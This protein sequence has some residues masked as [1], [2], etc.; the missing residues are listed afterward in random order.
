MG[1]FVVFQGS[2]GIGRVASCDGN[3]VEI[4]FFESAAEPRAQVV[5]K[6]ARD[7]RHTRLGE[8]SRVFFR[9]GA[10][11]WRAGR[12]VGGGPD[13]YFVRVPNLST[14]IEL[15]EDRLRIRWEK[16]PKDPL[17]VLLAGAHESP[18][19]R[20]ARLPVRSWLLSERAVTGSA[21]GIMSAG[22]K[23]H[24][25]QVD[26]ALRIIRDP[27]QRYLLA[28]EVGMGKTVQAGFVIRQLLIDDP[29]RKIGIIAPESLIPQWESELEQ[30]FHLSD[31]G[32]P[33]LLRASV[34]QQGW[35]DL[36]DVDLL[37]IDEAHLLAR[38]KDPR[39]SAYAELADLA[40]SVPRLLLLSATP[41][42]QD[43]TTHMALLHMLDPALFRWEEIQPFRTLLSTRR[44]LAM[45][46]FGL[47]VE[48][49][50]DNPELLEYQF[51]TVQG[52]LPDD[53]TLRRLISDAMASFRIG[54]DGAG[55]DEESLNRQ[56]AAV[57]THISE[58]YRLHHR[59]IRNRRHTVVK[60]QRDD[61]GIA[62]PFEFTGRSRPSVVRLDSG[63]TEAAVAAVD[64]WLSA[65]T[66]SVFDDELDAECYGAVAGILVSK[67]GG[68]VQDLQSV[69]E[70]RVSGRPTETGLSVDE[71]TILE[72]APLLP[73]E[74]QILASLAE[75]SKG[76]ALES[77][78][79]AI[80]KRCP[81]QARSLVFCGQ[82]ALAEHLHEALLQS[83]FAPA[84]VHAHLAGQGAEVREQA[85][86]DWHRDGGVLVVDETG[87]VGH[88][89]QRAERVIHAR[90]PWNPNL[91]EQRIGRVDRYG[92]SKTARH[93]VVSDLTREGIHGAW[94]RLLANGYNIFDESISAVQESIDASNQGAWARLIH[95]GVEGFES[96]AAKI[97][98]A[99]TESRRRIDEMDALEASYDS[100]SMGTTVTA[101]IARYESHTAAIEQSYRLLIEGAEGFRFL[102]NPRLDGSNLFEPDWMNKPLLSPRLLS[103]LQAPAES[104]AGFFDRWR[105]APGRRLFRR[106]NPFIDGIEA[107]LALDDRG[108]ASAL[109][110][111][112]PKW[113]NEPLVYFGFDFVVE[114]NPNHILDVLDGDIEMRP[115]AVRRA[116]S[117][118][119]PFQHRVW[120]PV[121]SL[122]AVV[123]SD[124]LR[125]LNA[126]FHNEGRDVNL[127]L[128]RISALYNV[129]GGETNLSPIAI[130]CASAARQQL[131]ALTD[132]EKRCGAARRR[133]QRETDGLVAQSR[134]R[135]SAA[136][137][138]A[139]PLA[140]E[141]EVDIGRAL[142]AGV[143]SPHVSVSSVTCVVRASEPWGIHA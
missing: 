4:E 128:Q 97:R 98:S 32:H 44:E 20:D 3:E 34:D 107:V 52:L 129:L 89:F 74:K 15:P 41:F 90:L 47:D 112:D 65:C 26:A 87:E 9:D 94:L 76:D 28:D 101:R 118:L 37:V 57:R 31:F 141:K 110:R 49:D 78:V 13:E 88:N 106:G 135:R 62:T 93:F 102:A 45:A 53:D 43:A 104:R 123:S 82:G 21:T 23:I 96:E 131:D 1:N 100:S 40:H 48:P 59:V 138:V 115:I 105:L 27:V 117:A 67:L 33:C 68:P 54:D 51:S 109:W 77:L 120:I 24:P 35:S 6:A 85:I 136:G 60:Q 103:H 125:F 134:A 64:E 121:N 130:G 18:R 17:Q 116:D 83:Q 10:G 12:I 22:V 63:E 133:I 126:K 29:T 132:L 139:D 2:S 50:P 84:K 66:N 14:D 91:L 114:A 113:K 7:V 42:S 79:E 16:P 92:Q 108:Q 39:T 99:L 70:Y 95:E 5:R 137:L 81:S 111:V 8:Q 30:K 56:V 36:A 73:F 75:T 19:F 119:P 122:E 69:L 143:L 72:Q 11:K 46:V 86:A 61:E 25:H 80:S 142:E 127:N 58:T 38:T 124:D 140:L 55:I 71:R